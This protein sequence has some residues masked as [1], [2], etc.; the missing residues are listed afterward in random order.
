MRGG[1]R[2]YG[3][4]TGIDITRILG[5]QPLDVVTVW[6]GTRS[7]GGFLCFQ[8]RP[9]VAAYR[10][11]IRSSDLGEFETPHRSAKKS[12]I[13]SSLSSRITLPAPTRRSRV[14]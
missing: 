5:S 14:V 7:V 6:S 8:M 4:K 12:S 2:C 3:G 9:I 1:C 13:W 11:Q 10:F